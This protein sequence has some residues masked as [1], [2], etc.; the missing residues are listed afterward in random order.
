MKSKGTQIFKMFFSSVYQILL[1]RNSSLHLKVRSGEKLVTA[2]L[3]GPDRFISGNKNALDEIFR[4][5]TKV[6]VPG[7]SCFSSWKQMAE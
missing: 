1:P 5:D 7:S 3:T 6:E 4:A 2:Y